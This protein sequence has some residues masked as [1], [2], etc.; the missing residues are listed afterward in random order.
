MDEYLI[1]FNESKT[2][3]YKYESYSSLF[4]KL[5]ARYKLHKIV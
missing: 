1:I 4:D 5:I 2:L 3:V